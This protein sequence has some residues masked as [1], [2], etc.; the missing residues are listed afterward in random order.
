MSN[1][2]NFVKK[3]G[4]FFRF[5]AFWVRRF[6]HRPEF[7]GIE[8]IPNEPCVI[9][10]NHC[11]AHTP[12]MGE[13]Y[14][15]VKKLTWCDAP[16]FDKKDMKAYAY[17]VFWGN[18]PKWYQR[19]AA[20]ILA[21]LIAY[22]MKNADALPVYRDMRVVKTYKASV[23][24]MMEGNN[25]LILP[26]C[27]DEHNEIINKLNEYFV[28]VARFYFKRTSKELL[29]VPMYYAPKIKKAVF[30]KPIKFD[31]TA[32]IEDERKRICSYIVDE[33]T[34]MAK[35]MPTHKVVPFNNVN[36]KLY[37]NSK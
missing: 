8:N 32:N 3:K 20:N 24:A 30:G 27:P 29:F 13:C 15:P 33:I 26:E 14:F 6:F 17:S 36:K 25:V 23:D 21:P 9:A 1:K 12:I 7:S 19:L 34:L 28:D 16:M 35:E 31:A 37:K 2:K 5:L 22:V 4:L 18:K 10:G 11:Q